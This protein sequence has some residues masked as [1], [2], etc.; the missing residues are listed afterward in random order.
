[1]PTPF[2]LLLAFVGIVGAVYLFAKGCEQ[3]EHKLME[4]NEQ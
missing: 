1:M 3:I 4:D 2:D